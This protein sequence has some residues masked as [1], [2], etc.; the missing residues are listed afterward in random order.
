MTKIPR[1]SLVVPPAFWEDHLDRGRRCHE[2]CPDQAA[3]QAEG[4]GVRTRKGYRVELTELDLAEL[5]SDARH[6]AESGIAT[7]GQDLMGLVAS[8]RGTLRRIEKARGLT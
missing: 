7:Y 5:E 3:H 2:R 4:L 8:A 1:L 6:Y